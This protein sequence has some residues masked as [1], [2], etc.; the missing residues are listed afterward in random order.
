LFFRCG[1]CLL[2]Y[3]LGSQL[4]WKVIAMGATLLPFTAIVV[5]FFVP[6]SPTFL[7]QKVR[8]NIFDL[9]KCRP[10]G[11]KLAPKVEVD[12]QR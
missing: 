3:T 5:A 2:T 9:E 8:G 1:G 7:V 12:P 4:S 11:V 10:L 6:E